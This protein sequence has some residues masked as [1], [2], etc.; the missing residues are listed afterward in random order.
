MTTTP[1]TTRATMIAN[2]IVLVA[3]ER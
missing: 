2:L 3:K 1:P